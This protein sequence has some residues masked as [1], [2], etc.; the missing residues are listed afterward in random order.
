[1]DVK[2]SHDLTIDSINEYL[3]GGVTEHTLSA[4]Y[5]AVY[6]KFWSLALDL[7]DEDE[8]EEMAENAREWNALMKKL[9]GHILAIMREENISIEEEEQAALG[10]FLDRNGYRSAGGWWFPGK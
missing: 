1:M 4:I 9:E 3:T 10:I 8:T 5:V 6:N 2:E 7:D